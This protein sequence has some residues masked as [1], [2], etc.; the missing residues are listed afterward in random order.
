MKPMSYPKPISG[1]FPPSR[2]AVADFYHKVY[3]PAAR[4]MARLLAAKMQDV[5]SAV[6]MYA[7]RNR[8]QISEYPI[9][10]QGIDEAKNG[11][12]S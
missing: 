12:L 3:S 10:S 11:G 7:D 8:R 2:D 6:K 1:S 9:V 4:Q 5:A